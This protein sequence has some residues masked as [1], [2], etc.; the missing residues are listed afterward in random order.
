MTLMAATA[1][2]QAAGDD[3]V[4]IEDL[5]VTATRTETNIDKVGGTSVTV[6][7][8]EEIQAKG[9]LTVEEV[10][11]GSPGIDVKANGGP[12][13]LTSVSIRGA[14]SKN[15]LVLIDG[16][17]VND[18]SAISRQADLANLTTDNIERIE[19]VRGPQSVL[20]GS[21][22]TAG[23]INIITRKGDGK[24]RVYAG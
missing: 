14:D 19:I 21:N 20:Y 12:G 9:Y 2:V 4:Q 10:L 3:P 5:V 11:K 6:I 17:M 24:P 16:I 22:A 13:T 15:T 18:A 1:T 8:T 7:T 23:V